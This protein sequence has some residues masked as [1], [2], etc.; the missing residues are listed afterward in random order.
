MK[1]LRKKRCPQ[2]IFALVLLLSS[3]AAFSDSSPDISNLTIPEKA[4]VCSSIDDEEDRNSDWELICYDQ[5][6]QIVS[7]FRYDD[8]ALPSDQKTL[9]YKTAVMLGK[10]FSLVS[11]NTRNSRKRYDYYG[12]TRYA[13]YNKVEH[14][15]VRK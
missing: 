12:E 4:K 1:S 5:A 10:G 9:G 15:F 6:G 3:H 8:N 7:K 11:S 2:F 13:L 14:V